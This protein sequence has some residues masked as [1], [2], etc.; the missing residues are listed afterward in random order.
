MT[1]K[2]FI[3][4]IYCKHDWVRIYKDRKAKLCVKCGK[5][6]IPKYKQNDLSI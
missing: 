5:V 4:Q 1:I 2:Q 6:Y 3:K